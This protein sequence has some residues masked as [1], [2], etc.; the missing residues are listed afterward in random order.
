MLEQPIEGTQPYAAVT[1][2]VPVRF[3]NTRTTWDVWCAECERLV[4]PK[5]SRDVLIGNMDILL[6]AFCWDAI[7]A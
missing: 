7:A 1:I 4:D 6:C 3:V 5:T 2:R